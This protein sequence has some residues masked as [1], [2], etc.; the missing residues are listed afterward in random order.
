MKRN[1]GTVE[2][3][4]GSSSFGRSPGGPYVYI[5]NDPQRVESLSFLERSVKIFL[6]I[7]FL[8]TQWLWAVQVMYAVKV[9]TSCDSCRQR[10]VRCLSWWSRKVVL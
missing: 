8:W 9:L 10:K 6:Q 5:S 7:T 2:G 1:V 3:S 4:E